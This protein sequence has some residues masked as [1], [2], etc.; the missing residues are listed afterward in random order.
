MSY[1]ES[2]REAQRGVGGGC[3]LSP[4][5]RAEFPTLAKVLEG[6]QAE[7]EGETPIPPA[8]VTL[9]AEGGRLKFVIRPKI[10][11]RVAFGTVRDDVKG[12]AGLDCE[13]QAG[14]FEWKL[15]KR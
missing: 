12:L 9:F 14:A 2:F 5:F 3:S 11:N 10:G 13:L 6:C 1:E 8:G 15:S 7:R 4:E